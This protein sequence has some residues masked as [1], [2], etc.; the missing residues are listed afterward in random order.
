MLGEN[1]GVEKLVISEN[2]VVSEK[3]LPMETLYMKI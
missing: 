3:R 2:S 1:K